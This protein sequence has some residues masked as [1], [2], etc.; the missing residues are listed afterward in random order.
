[1]GK[2]VPE[3]LLSGHHKN[4]EAWRREQSKLRTKERRPDLWE[5]Y[6]MEHPSVPIDARTIYEAVWDERYLPSSNNTVMVHVLNLRKKLEEL[7]GYTFTD[8]EWERFFSECI[9]NANDGI[10]DKTRRIQEDF[11]QVLRRDTGE[12]KNITLIDKKN[13]HNNR[14]QVINQYA[15]GK[16]DGAQ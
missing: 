4:I 15:A 5:Q 2:K 3:I 1:M 14:L 16:E 9:A 11:V 6:L 8:S 7:N 12:S 10:E 13:I